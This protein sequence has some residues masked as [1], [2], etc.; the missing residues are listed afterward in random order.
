MREIV[1]P[2]VKSDSVNFDDLPADA[3]AQIEQLRDEYAEQAKSFLVQGA[4][5]P[6]RPRTRV[7]GF[8]S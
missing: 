3:R 8:K 6:R 7:K 4:R 5:G 1:M 2:Y